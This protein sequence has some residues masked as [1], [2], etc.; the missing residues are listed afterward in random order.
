ME[1]LAK[2][3]GHSWRSCIWLAEEDV[4]RVQLIEEL[5][6]RE[7]RMNE[8]ANSESPNTGS[9]RQALNV[10]DKPPQLFPPDVICNNE[11]SLAFGNSEA[12]E[13]AL[14]YE[15]LNS[16]HNYALPAEVE[17]AHSIMPL[18]LPLSTT[19]VDS[20]YSM[21]Y[22]LCTDDDPI[23]VGFQFPIPNGYFSDQMQEPYG[24]VPVDIVVKELNL[25]NPSS[26]YFMTYA[27]A[28]LSSFKKLILI[29]YNIRSP[30][31][32]EFAFAYQLL[33]EYFSLKD[34]VNLFLMGQKMYILFYFRVLKLSVEN[35]GM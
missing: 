31:D 16:F 7:R 12:D 10:E 28:K 13:N 25:S 32:I 22:E 6:E 26:C 20:L 23:S 21:P 8:A 5:E 18:P 17:P 15:K 9:T 30:Y 4:H 24:S 29:K 1:Y 35:A 27:K 34:I 14:E 11:N 19:W 33:P 2:W 3:Q